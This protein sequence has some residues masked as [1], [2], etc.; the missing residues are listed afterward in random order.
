M[1][2]SKPNRFPGIMKMP[3]MMTVYIKWF[4]G[5]FQEQEGQKVTLKPSFII[6]SNRFKEQV[7]EKSCLN[8]MVTVS[9]ENKKYSHLTLRM[10]VL[11][12]LCEGTQ[13][14][15]VMLYCACCCSVTKCVQL[16]S[17]PGFPILH[18]F[19]VR[20]SLIAQKVKNLPSSQVTWVWSLG[21]E[22]T[23]EKEMATQFSNFA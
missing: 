10:R 19:P 11:R 3:R 23:L 9:P 18:Y 7:E 4:A 20:A 8:Q 12:F 22:D 14:H 15:R 1:K 13:G 21:R 16:C 17:S 5:H 6:V 2:F